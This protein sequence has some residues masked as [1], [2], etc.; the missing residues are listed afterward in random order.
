PTRDVSRSMRRLAIANIALHLV[1]LACAA[2][3]MRPGTPAALLND[4]MD[5]LA[6]H[7]VGW[8]L[9]WS[10]WI[11]CIFLMVAFAAAAA[12]R[13]PDSPLARLAV[14]VAVAA[15]SFDLL[16]DST[17]IIVFPQVAG[18]QPRNMQLFLAVERVTQ[19]I[20][21]VVANGLYSVAT[22]L[23]TL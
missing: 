2:V 20:S 8:A 18:L 10:V 12:Q 4:R 22:L 23:L 9:G 21:L 11:G 7:P 17:Y 3:W 19:A 13:M 1:G 16:G 14:V 15:G 6:G 5:Y